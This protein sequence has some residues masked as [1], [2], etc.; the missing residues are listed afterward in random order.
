MGLLF[1]QFVP[2][3]GNKHRSD[4][5]LLHL[6][7]VAI[8]DKEIDL[9]VAGRC[10]SWTLIRGAWNVAQSV[11]FWLLFM[12]GLMG[13]FVQLLGAEPSIVVQAELVQQLEKLG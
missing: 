5:L 12:C 11:G 6:L 2:T 8:G 9:L 4:T 1:L 10:G 7:L 13:D 3:R